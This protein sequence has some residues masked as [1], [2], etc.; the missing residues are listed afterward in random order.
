MP[1]NSIT[2]PLDSERLDSLSPVNCGFSNK[3][4]KGYKI[5][6]EYK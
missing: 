1:I 5:K 6:G 3:N 2:H 4:I